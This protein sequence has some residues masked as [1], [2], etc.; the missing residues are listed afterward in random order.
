M[1][2]NTYTRGLIAIALLG[3]GIDLLAKWFIL[4]RL[5]LPEGRFGSFFFSIGLHK[6]PGIAFD[7]PVPFFILLPL[8][9]FLLIGLWYT[10]RRYSNQP[11]LKAGT[12]TII[13][14]AVGNLIDRIWHGFTTDYLI[15]FDRSAINLSDVLIVLGVIVLFKAQKSKPSTTKG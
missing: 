9:V 4:E 2:K 5:S 13:I 7:I 8:S 10:T 1:Q 15:F 3:G 11:W 14:G 6:N 12:F